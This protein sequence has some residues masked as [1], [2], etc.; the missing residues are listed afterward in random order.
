MKSFLNSII[1][2]FIVVN[3][4][5]CL[6]DKELIGPDADGA[7]AANIIEIAS[8]SAPASG[9]TSSVVMYS[10]AFDQAPSANYEVKIRCAGASAA[11]TDIKVV[12]SVDNSLITAYNSGNTNKIVTLSPDAYTLTQ[13]EVIIKKGE[14]EAIVPITIKPELLKFDANYAIPIKIVS[15]SHGVVSGNFGSSL[16]NIIPKNKY[17]GV[18]TLTTS[19]LT[20]LAANSVKT[21]ELVTLGEYAVSLSP[22]LLG[23]YSNAV[24]YTIDP[25]NNRVEVGMTTLLPVATDVSSVYDPASKT[26]TLKWTSNG[27]ARLFEETIKYV[28]PRP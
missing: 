9:V 7:G 11:E 22:G 17:D 21:V 15:A 8:P 14:R 24:T 1:A 3:F 16:F 28:G 23:I 2:L 26:F 20:T 13:T 5:S 19:A 10:K 27:G 4:S 25:V 6:K 12:I 18:Y